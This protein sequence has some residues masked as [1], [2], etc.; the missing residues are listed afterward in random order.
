[1]N[2]PKAHEVEQHSGPRGNPEYMDRVKLLEKE[3][4]YYKDEVNKAQTEVERLLDILREVETEKNDKDKKI[5]ELERQGGKDLTKKGPNIKLGPQGEKKGL[6]QDPR[7]DSSMDSGHHVKLEELM[8]TL[9][10]TRQELDSTKQRLSSTQ[11]S[12]QERDGHLT[13]MRQER[14]KQLEEILEMK[15][16]ALLAA[17]SEKDANIAL[18]ELSASNKKKTQEEVLSLKRERDKLMHQLKQHVSTAARC[19]GKFCLHC[20]WLPQQM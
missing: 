3:V 10:R 12:L 9:E 5:A 13:N 1:M 4:S 2:N 14:R 15:Q 19:P 11:Q 17:I 8:N 6:G 20:S 18:L 16:Q 7:K